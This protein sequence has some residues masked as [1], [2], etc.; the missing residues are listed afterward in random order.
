MGK[1]GD[2][3][4]KYLSLNVQTLPRISEFGYWIGDVI[5]NDGYRITYRG[6]KSITDSGLFS[7]SYLEVFQK[8]QDHH[9]L[10]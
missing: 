6:H 7:D 3:K 4:Q 5:F 2:Q 1:D 9:R 8:H 10:I